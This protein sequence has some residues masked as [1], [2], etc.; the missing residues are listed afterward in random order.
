MAKDKKKKVAKD[1]KSG[2]KSGGGFKALAK[3]PLAAEIVASALVATAAAL[4]DSKKARQLAADAGDELSKLSVAGAKR[5]EALWEM[6]LDIGRR[7]LEA[8]SSDT[9]LKAKAKPANRK[10]AKPKPK[11]K[12]K[13][14]TS[15]KKRSS[16]AKAR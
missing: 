8:L 3:N 10:S 11:A 2:N 9:P 16:P 4:R 13:P 15:A 14:K 6:A 7:S 5:G 1:K 12:A